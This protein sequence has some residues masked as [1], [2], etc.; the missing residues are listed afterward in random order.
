MREWKEGGKKAKKQR[1]ERAGAALHSSTHSLN[2]SSKLAAFE[3]AL[4]LA[5]GAVDACG[6]IRLVG[7]IV[8]V[9]F[10]GGGVRKPDSMSTKV[11]SAAL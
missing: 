9:T 10:F 11:W 6:H 2:H 5:E 4:V 1:A 7:F 8:E 3:L